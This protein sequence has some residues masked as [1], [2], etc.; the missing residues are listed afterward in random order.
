MHVAQPSGTCFT[1]IEQ[2]GHNLLSSK[3][4]TLSHPSVSYTVQYALSLSFTFLCVESI[5]FARW[6]AGGL[7]YDY[8]RQRNVSLHTAKKLRFM[9]SQK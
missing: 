6:I 4:P 8:S 9:Y 1:S 5:G 7:V 3:F 2:G